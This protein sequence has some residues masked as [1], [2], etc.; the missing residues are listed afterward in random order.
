MSYGKLNNF[1]MVDIFRSLRNFLQ[2]RE[3]TISLEFIKNN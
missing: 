2:V 1:V 3:F